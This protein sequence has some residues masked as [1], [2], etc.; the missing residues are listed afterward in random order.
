MDAGSYFSDVLAGID[1]LMALAS[2]IGFF[3]AIVGV[4][5]LFLGGRQFKSKALKVIMI[6][7]ILLALFGYQ[8]GIKYFRL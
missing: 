5:L 1:F 3:G 6:S 4:A 2:L 7:I 8:T